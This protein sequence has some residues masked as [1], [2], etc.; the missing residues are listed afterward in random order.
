MPAGSRVYTGGRLDR[1]QTV[2]VLLHAPRTLPVR[3]GLPVPGQRANVY[4][5]PKLR[6]SPSLDLAL[7]GAVGGRAMRAVRL[8]KRGRSAAG[9]LALHLGGHHDPELRD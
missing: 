7:V 6:R 9:D 8:R 3:S 5:P 1:V 2:I 4:Q